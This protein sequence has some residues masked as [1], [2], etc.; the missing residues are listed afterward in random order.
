M[1]LLIHLKLFNLKG[2]IDMFNNG[3][4]STKIP[5][6]KVSNNEK[7]EVIRKLTL[8]KFENKELRRPLTYFQDYSVSTL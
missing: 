2:K 6:V 1:D 8:C 4:F 3:L 5:Y 7:Q